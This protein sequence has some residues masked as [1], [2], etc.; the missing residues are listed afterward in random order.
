LT[1]TNRSAL[2]EGPWVLVM[3]MHRSGTSAVAG[4]LGHFGLQLPAA[5]DLMTGRYDNP[6]HYESEALIGVD[7]QLLR[8]LGGSWSAPP[9]LEDGW[10]TSPV[11]RGLRERAIEAAWR[12]FPEEGPIAWKDP[13]LCL[14]F[15]FWS[16]LLETRTVSV[17]VW[18]APMAVARSLRSRQGFT[19]SH[20]L[21]LWYVYAR[22]ALTSLAGTKVMVTSYEELTGNRRDTLFEMAHW[23][24]KAGAVR[25]PLDRREVDRA[26]ASISSERSREHDDAELPQPLGAAQ[27][28][29]RSLEGSHE[30]LP[31]VSLP[32]PPPWAADSIIQRRD[33]EDLYR[34]YM[35]Y[36]RWRRRI[37]LSRLFSGRG[38]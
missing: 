7:D 13:R 20:G 5:G 35:R 14:L 26:T 17:L 24:E 10:Q 27:D 36:I 6:V 22:R 23:L 12:A 30:R 19:L 15:P 38:R 18:R 9:S 4:A 28:A 33:Y 11:A 1:R 25:G 21:S 29:L 32:E 2:P 34:R 37:P 31:E 16:S 3:G 8:A